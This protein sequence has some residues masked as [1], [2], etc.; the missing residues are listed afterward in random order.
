MVKSKRLNRLVFAVIM[1]VTAVGLSMA[2]V[3][4]AEEYSFKVHNTT[5]VTITK[6]LVSQDKKE[7]GEFE[8]GKGIKAGEEVALGWDDSTN[9][10]ECKQWVKAVFSDKSESEPSKFDFCEKDLELEF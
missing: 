2:Q 6:I 1:S 4:A 7:W 3:Q 8:I 9:D 5:K 10:E